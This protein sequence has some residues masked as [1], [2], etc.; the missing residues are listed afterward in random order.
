MRHAAPSRVSPMSAGVLAVLVSVTGCG[1]GVDTQE[2]VSAPTVSV[3]F[4]LPVTF[5]EQGRWTMRVAADSD[6]VELPEG[7]AVLLPG[8][9]NPEDYRVAMLAPEDGSI[10]WV[11][12]DFSAPV[13]DSVPSLGAVSD[14]GQGWLIAT[15]QVSG[16]EVRVDVYRPAGTGDRRV[17]EVSAVLTGEGEDT[18]PVVEVRD[19]G[20]VVSTDGGASFRPFDPATGETVEYSGPGEPRASWGDGVVVSNPSEGAGFGYVVNGQAVWQSSAVPPAGVNRDEPAELVTVGAG[21][22]LALWHGQGGASVLALHQVRTGEVVAAVSEVDE[23]TIEEARGES[24]VQSFDGGWLS[25]GS[26]LFGVEKPSSAIVDLRHG[27]VSSIYRDVLYVEDASG[28]LTAKAAAQQ[29]SSEGVQPGSALV[30]GVESLR[31]FAG[32]V[33]AS[34]G[35]PLTNEMPDAVPQFMSDVSQGVFVVSSNGATRL[36]SVPLS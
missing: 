11:S 21:M 34:T 3:P 35:A 6:P 28:P 22:V 7:I 12:D 8:R 27:Q 19:G 20:V 1:P 24:L 10:R 25:W 18:V 33:D 9:E 2:Q 4:N 14:D 5:A 16:N 13:A 32:M 29:E 23:Q 31:S 36:Y 17:A 26:V 30:A 15:T